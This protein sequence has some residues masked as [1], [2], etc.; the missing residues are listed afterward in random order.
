MNIV[1]IVIKRTYDDIE[2]KSVDDVS[3]KPCAEYIEKHGHH[4]NSAL[5]E[6]AS[7]LMENANG[8]SHSWT[9]AQVKSTM[10][11]LGLTIP[12]NVTYGD[13]AYLANMYYADLYPEPLT[14][15]NACIKAAYKVCND[16]DGYEGMIFNR[17]M[18][19]I[20]GKGISIDW[21]KFI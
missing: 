6:Y 7:S 14:D 12:S 18:S 13:A 10:I 2:E 20:N 15:E 11:S 8:K 21:K 19:D 1:G 16:V 17:W 3:S 4:F 9:T 5:A